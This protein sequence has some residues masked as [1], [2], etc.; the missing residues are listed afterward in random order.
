MCSAGGE[1]KKGLM[2]LINKKSP[3]IAVVPPGNDNK[4][5][6]WNLTEFKF[7]E[8]NIISIGSE[9]D[10]PLSDI[11]DFMIGINPEVTDIIAPLV[12]IVPLQLLSYY[13]ALKKG[14]DPDKPKL[15]K[16]IQV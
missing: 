3:L 11:S 12:Y 13:L 7:F 5:T 1:V 9:N 14:Y 2:H 6:I 10:E 15:L 16:L 8:S 4:K